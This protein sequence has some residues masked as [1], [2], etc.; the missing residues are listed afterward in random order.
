M[1]SLKERKSQKY[2][3]PLTALRWFKKKK[4]KVYLPPTAEQQRRRYWKLHQ[5]PLSLYLAATVSPRSGLIRIRPGRGGGKGRSWRGSSGAPGAWYCFRGHRKGPSCPS[6]R[7]VN[8]IPGLRGHRGRRSA[9]ASQLL[10]TRNRGPKTHP[11]RKQR[12]A[13]ARSLWPPMLS[14]SA[15]SSAVTMEDAKLASD[16]DRFRTYN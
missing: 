2:P 15:S 16:S 11:G 13:L 5:A 8:L 4:K 6:L 9:A 7:T 12:S 1:L 14:P 10:D 3:I